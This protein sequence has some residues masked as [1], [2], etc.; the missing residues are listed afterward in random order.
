MFTRRPDLHREPRII[1]A[2]RTSCRESTM[3]AEPRMLPSDDALAVEFTAVLKQGDVDRLRGLLAA[4]PWLATC[5]V[6][7]PK[8]SGRTP[9]HLFADWPGHCPN[10][11]A[12]VEM[13]VAAGADL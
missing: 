9:L 13:L 8:G 11:E 10:P 1:F 7:S 2:A 12:I 6:V 4:D 5:V 3:M